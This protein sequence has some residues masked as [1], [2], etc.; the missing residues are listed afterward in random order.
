MQ[1]LSPYL[2]L[3]TFNTGYRL[4]FVK[5]LLNVTQQKCI[6]IIRLKK[7]NKKFADIFLPG[8]VQDYLFRNEASQ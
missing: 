7:I 8:L 3:T 1:I 2:K 6:Q 5:S 4:V